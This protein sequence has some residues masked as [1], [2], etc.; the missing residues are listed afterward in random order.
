MRT[1]IENYLHFM[2]NCIRPHY[3]KLKPLK[4]GFIENSSF[5]NSRDPW[6]MFKCEGSSPFGGWDNGGCACSHV[7]KTKPVVW[8][9]VNH[10]NIIEQICDRFYSNSIKQ[11]DSNEINKGLQSQQTLLKYQE[12]VRA[13]QL[14]HCFSILALLSLGELHEPPPWCCA[15]K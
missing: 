10:I 15:G 3:E 8:Y 5:E 11:N 4:S 2:K 1:F 13:A 6:I 9:S 7:L 14:D 12:R